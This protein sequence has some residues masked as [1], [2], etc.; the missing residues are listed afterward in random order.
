MF[1]F[2]D[3][4]ISQIKYKVSYLENLGNLEAEMWID[5]YIFVEILV[6]LE[7]IQNVHNDQK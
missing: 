2:L 5:S 1:H 3:V 6:L 7:A 4:R